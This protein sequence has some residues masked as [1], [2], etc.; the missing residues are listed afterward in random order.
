MSFGFFGINHEHLS[1]Y[2]LLIGIVIIIMT[3][4]MQ[5]RSRNKKNAQK[6]SRKKEAIQAAHEA[7]QRKIAASGAVPKS[8][9]G[10]RPSERRIPLEDHTATL[11]TGNAMPRQ[12][13]RWETEIHQIGREIIGRIDSKMVALQTLTLEANRSANRL[14]ILVEHL[15]A[16]A[17]QITDK[18]AKPA[19]EGEQSEQT[20]IPF[21]QNAE[22][23]DEAEPLV[24]VL[25][26]LKAGLDSVHETIQQQTTL[27]S[28]LAPLTILQPVPPTNAN[29]SN[30]AKDSAVKLQGQVLPPSI[31]LTPLNPFA[32]DSLY[33]EQQDT[34]PDQTLDKQDQR[35]K[36]ATETVPFAP[37]DAPPKRAGGS[38]LNLRREVE[39][40]ADYGYDAKRIAEN[41]D[42]SVNE[43]E[44][45]LELRADDKPPKSGEK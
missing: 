41:F 30:D 26:E 18:I 19:I 34:T 45:M 35:D 22:L 23:L 20:V 2:L 24:N 25:R 16:L 32:I 9:V 11:F 36:K 8:K 42:I 31:S 37:T 21:H 29:N 40:L 33:A 4:V 43:V 14:E 12:F 38:H 6:Q 5:L 15:E 3:L 39:M 10:N 7:A 28:E 1:E 13:A 27:Q 17:K 44:L